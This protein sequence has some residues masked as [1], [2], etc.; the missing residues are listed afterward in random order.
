MIFADAIQRALGDAMEADESVICYGLGV[1]DPKGVFGTTIGLQDR[2]SSERVFDMPASENAMTGV[3]IGAALNGIRPVMTHQ[4]MDFFLLAMDQLV[5]NAAKWRFMFGG[6]G[7]VP[8][9]IRLIIGRGWGQ[10]PTHAQNLQA[11]LAHVPGLKVVSPCFPSEAYHLLREAITDPDPVVYLE[12]R[13]LH[14]LEE[15]SLKEKVAN[16]GQATVVRDGTDVTIVAS[17]YMVIEALRAADW[18]AENGVSCEIVN[19]TS[20][21]PMDLKTTNSSVKRTGRILI[22]DTSNPICSMASEISATVAEECWS[23]LKIPPRRLTLPDTPSPTSF[24]LTKD[25]Y[26]G[27]IEIAHNVMDMCN[28]EGK[29]SYDVT[30][31]KRF[32]HDVPGKWF[33]GPF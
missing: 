2:F 31:L 1:P 32:P 4:R 3:A 15:P 25:Y 18:L 28:C 12:H 8:I 20:L 23:Y 30:G 7:N 19:N 13:W 27:A 6:N 21:R 33:Q 9:V 14:Q 10:G 24:A 29:D 16:I 11:W 5:N 26:P 22:L 17:S